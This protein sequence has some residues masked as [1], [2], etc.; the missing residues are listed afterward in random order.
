LADTPPSVLI[1]EDDSIIAWHLASMVRRLG[2]TVCATA[3]TEDTALAAA[4]THA[5]DIVLMDVRLA[6]LDDGVRA[7]EAIRAE[8]DVPIVFCT[9]HAD[10]PSFEARIAA[11]EHS[12]VLGK[13]VNERQ[14]KAALD[15]LLRPVR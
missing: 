8:R 11:F 9:A 6:S 12:A 3:V 4:R 15:G 7:A 1:V 2:Y 5:P 14:L 10:E 13:P